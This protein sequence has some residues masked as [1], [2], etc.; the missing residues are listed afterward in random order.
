ME[1]DALSDLESVPPPAAGHAVPVAAAQGAA[2]GPQVPQHP[3]WER[4]AGRGGGGGGGANK[5]GPGDVVSR[6]QYH[7][8]AVFLANS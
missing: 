5:N 3:L 1:D 7:S 2:N 6:F 8:W 4:A